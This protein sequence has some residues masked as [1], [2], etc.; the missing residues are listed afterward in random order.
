[1][2]ESQRGSLLSLLDFME[3]TLGY[4][5]KGTPAY[6]Q[7]VKK[8]T[9]ITMS[10][11]PVHSHSGDNHKVTIVVQVNYLHKFI[12]R[13]WVSLLLHHP[14]HQYS[15]GLRIKFKFEHINLSTAVFV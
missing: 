6:E 12:Q 14:S 9:D 11:K 7:L 15:E 1:M 10:S 8:T 3:K 2:S 5:V 13:Y 4:S